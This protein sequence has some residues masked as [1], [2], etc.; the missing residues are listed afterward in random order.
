MLLFFEMSQKTCMVRV[1]PY[2]AQTI[3]GNMRTSDPFGA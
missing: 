1:A 2:K 3:P